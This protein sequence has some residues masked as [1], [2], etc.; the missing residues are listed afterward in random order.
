MNFKTNQVARLL[1]PGEFEI[2]EENI[3][4]PKSSEVIIATSVS[5]IC[6]SEIPF[7]TGDAV[8][9]EREFI[10]YARYPAPLGHEVVGEIV[11][12]GNEVTQFKEGDKVTGFTIKGSGFCQYYREIESNLV[13]VPDSIPDEHALGEPIMCVMNVLR[14][15]EPE[16]GDLA[17]VI[18]DGFMGLMLISLLSH[19]PLSGLILVG[20]SD[21]KLELGKELGATNCVNVLKED[22]YDSL[23]KYV[24]KNKRGAD[25]VVE[26]AGN[27]KALS[28]SAWAVRARRGKLVMPS[29]YF[30]KEPFEIGGYLMR[31]GPRLIPAHP[32]YSTDNIDDLRRGIWALEKGMI[33]MDKL[34][35][36]RFPFKD[37]NNAFHI[38]SHKPENYIK[39]LIVFN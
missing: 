8:C 30:K 19:Y 39:G 4:S 37:I 29:Y 38:A 3:S 15:C 18:G 20:M 14:N 31:K 26:F 17:I 11:A 12:V 28:L 34:I 7:F 33:P 23:E 35:T 36:H 16:H 13:K 24:G 10:K 21:Y 5:G 2:T 25:I 1:R 6:S 22:A 9:S 27:M 32:A